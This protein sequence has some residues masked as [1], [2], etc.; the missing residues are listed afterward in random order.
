ME[1]PVTLTR[2]DNDTFLVTFPDVPEAVT[3]GDTKEAALEHAVDALLTIFDARIKD[4]RDIP[5]PSARKSGPH[6]R[7]PALE[8][9]KIELYRSELC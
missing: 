5:I 1:Y 9:A 2:D 4:R 6:V 7:L 3:Y 8:S